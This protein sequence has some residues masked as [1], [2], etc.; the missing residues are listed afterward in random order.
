MGFST[1]TICHA[2]TEDSDRSSQ[3]VLPTLD[4]PVELKVSVTQDPTTQSRYVLCVWLC[5]L[6]AMHHYGSVGHDPSGEGCSGQSMI[7]KRGQLTNSQ[8]RPCKRNLEKGTCV[9]R[10][11]FLLCQGEEG[12]FERKSSD[13]NPENGTQE[14]RRCGASAP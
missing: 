4:C 2:A 3:S 11:A 14:P 9:H 12:K 5:S 8:P 13:S 10:P 7:G 6:N 1:S